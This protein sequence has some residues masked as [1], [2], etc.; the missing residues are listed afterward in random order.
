MTQSQWSYLLNR[1]SLW[2]LLVTSACLPD[3]RAG[4][5]QHRTEWFTSRSAFPVTAYPLP[6]P[7]HFPRPYRVE[8]I[9]ISD[10]Q[11]MFS[12]IAISLTLKWNKSNHCIS[13]SRTPL[14]QYYRWWQRLANPTACSETSAGYHLADLPASF[15]WSLI[16]VL[17]CC[18]STLHSTV[19]HEDCSTRDS[20]HRTAFSSLPNPVSWHFITLL[21]KWVQSLVTPSS[22]KQPPCRISYGSWHS[23]D[24]GWSPVSANLWSWASQVLSK[25]HFLC[26]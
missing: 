18:L 15:F 21:P 11:K 9:Q 7:P 5:P 26:L 14:L 19:R 10:F 8:P 24:L 17:H 16:H 6:P 3:P 12:P 20:R 13:L 1:A 25:P 23:I 22:L 2:S 4:S